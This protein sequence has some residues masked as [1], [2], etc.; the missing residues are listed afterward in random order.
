[1]AQLI[2][3]AELTGGTETVRCSTIDGKT[4]MSIRDIITVVCAQTQKHACV[5]WDRLEEDKKMEVATF[6]R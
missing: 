6:R 5:T 4:Y 1:M 3:F 2:S